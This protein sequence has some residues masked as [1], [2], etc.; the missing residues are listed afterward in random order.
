MKRFLIGA[1]TLIMTASVAMGQISLLN[2]ATNGLF[3][4]VN[5]FI[6]K[7][8]KMFKSHHKRNIYK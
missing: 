6:I 7:P 1:V 2:E 3:H 5:D 8:N 4:N